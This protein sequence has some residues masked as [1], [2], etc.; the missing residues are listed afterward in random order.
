VDALPLETVPLAVF[1]FKIPPILFRLPPT[2]SEPL[3]VHG[4][5]I[6]PE[7]PKEMRPL[8]VRA[9]V[10]T[11][12]DRWPQLAGWPDSA[13]VLAQ[14]QQLAPQAASGASA[15]PEAGGAPA[16]MSFAPE[17]LQV[18]PPAISKPN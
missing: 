11:F 13:H 15:P 17:M 5:L 8:S 6:P 12:G 18:L 2:G 14:L 4:A 7:S 10:T 1:Q 9:E 16:F 3:N